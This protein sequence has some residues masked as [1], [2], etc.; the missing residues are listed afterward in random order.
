MV[1]LTDLQ[2]KK[3]LSSDGILP[4]RVH[5]KFEDLTGES[6]LD[7]ILTNQQKNKITKK[8]EVGGAGYRIK[9]SNS[10]I[11]NYHK[12]QAV[13]QIEKTTSGGNQKK[14]IT[15]DKRE[16]LAKKLITDNSRVREVLS[17]LYHQMVRPLVKAKTGRQPKYNETIEK[18]MM[19]YIATQPDFLNQV[20]NLKKIDDIEMFI[21]SIYNEEGLR[22]VKKG[23]G[24]LSD[25]WIGTKKVLVKTAEIATHLLLNTGKNVLNTLKKRYVD[26]PTSLIALLGM[27]VD[28]S[29]TAGPAGAVSVMVNQIGGVIAPSFLDALK[30]ELDEQLSAEVA[31]PLKGVV[32]VIKNVSTAKNI[33][34]QVETA[35]SGKLAESAIQA[36]PQLEGV[37]DV[38]LTGTQTAKEILDVVPN[39]GFGKKRGRG[40]P[41]KNAQLTEI[42]NNKIKEL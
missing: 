13:K 29:L 6:E 1:K 22:K 26:N 24:V 27:I 34:N 33:V 21:K 35:L 8:L 18:A 42:L 7:K 2:R 14:K 32:N 41:K 40:R 15:Q 31:G 28:A 37:K 23:K 16:E 12:N 5:V 11:K 10:Q 3:I 19:M 9:L 36:V 17:E 30:S 39:L 4:I 38:A 25:I 20:N